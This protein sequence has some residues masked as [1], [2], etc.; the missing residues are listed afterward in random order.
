MKTLIAWVYRAGLAVQ[1]LGLSFTSPRDQIDEI[2]GDL[3]R[4][5]VLADRFIM[6]NPKSNVVDRYQQARGPYL[7]PQLH[8]NALT[9]L[10][11][12]GLQD[13]TLT[14]YIA[15][16]FALSHAGWIKDIG[17]SWGVDTVR[18]SFNGLEVLQGICTDHPEFGVVVLQ[19][20][21]TNLM[22]RE[23]IK[24]AIPCD[25]HEHTK[26]GRPCEAESDGD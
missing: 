4:P 17:Q 3:A 13:C 1:T 9:V 16:D 19:A 22:G 7:F 10:A 2:A 20:S 5:Y 6:P 21:I 12:H 14:Q 11:Q 23:T 26:G 8:R 18:D 24:F 15:E 25:C